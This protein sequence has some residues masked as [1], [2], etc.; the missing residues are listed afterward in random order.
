[1]I[2]RT[3]LPRSDPKQRDDMHEPAGGPI[4]AHDQRPGSLQMHMQEHYVNTNISLCPCS[5]QV[6]PETKTN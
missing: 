6:Q 5:P 4:D 2:R 3:T 1:M